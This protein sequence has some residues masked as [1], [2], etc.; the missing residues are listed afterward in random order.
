MNKQ[1]V[2]RHVLKVGEV[3]GFS[4]TGAEDR[5]VSRLLVDEDSVGA[6]S[7]VV[8][9]FTLRAGQ[10]TDMG[11]HPCPYEEVYYVLRG[12]AKFTLGGEKGERFD[13]SPDMVAYIPCE[14]DHQIEN[15]G[16]EDLEMITIMPFR[17]KPGVNTLYDERKR[18]WGTSFRVVGETGGSADEHQERS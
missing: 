13:L 3:V 15:V 11:Q 5:Y 4:P 6:Q 10:K 9:H 18:R 1:V 14:V 7:L 17:L 2:R 8:N 12:H 16:A